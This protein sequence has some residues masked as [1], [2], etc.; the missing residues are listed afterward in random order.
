MIDIYAENIL[1]HYKN[2]RHEGKLE[3]ASVSA[4][5]NNPLCGDKMKLSLLVSDGMIKDAV[6]SGEGCAISKAS[7]DL[8]LDNVIGKSVEEASRIG[9]DD[10]L[11]MI[12]IEVSGTR[13]K[14]A[15][16]GYH[17]MKEALKDLK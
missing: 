1:D 9:T 14:C 8:L 10:L 13:M 7:M 2:P 5:G 12:G 16:L 11:G 15:T 6:F 4:E 17:A 3:R